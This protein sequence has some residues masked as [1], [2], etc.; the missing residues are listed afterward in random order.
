M[1]KIFI[2]N[3]FFGVGALVSFGIYWYSQYR[4]IPE[5]MVKSDFSEVLCSASE[6]RRIQCWQNQVEATLTTKGLDAAFE[7][8]AALFA[9]ETDFAQ[10]CHSFMH[11]LGQAAYK[12]FAKH[13]EISL[14]QKTSYCGFG[15]YHGFLEAMVFQTG[16]IHGAREFCAYAEQQLSAQNSDAKGACYHGIG[17]G[18]VDGSDSRSWGDEE[19]VISPGLK[20]CEEVT[21]S[22]YFINR[23]ASGVFNSLANLYFD[24]K[25]KLAIDPADPFRICRIQT[26]Q[27]FKKPCYEE[28]NTALMRLANNDFS[29][30]VG[31]LARIDESGYAGDAASSLA[32][33]EAHGYYRSSDDFSRVVTVCR[34]LRG[35]VVSSCLVGF[36]AGLV[37]HSP[38]G[39]EGKAAVRFCGSEKLQE[40]ERAACFSRV[41][42]YLGVVTTKEKLQK[43]CQTLDEK[44]KKYCPSEKAEEN[45]GKLNQDTAS[46]RGLKIL[47]FAGGRKSIASL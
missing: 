20:L 4:G 8:I 29:K 19:A 33:V 44:Y 9:T 14:T 12:K 1:K 2:K 25:Y 17:H 32:G 3:F 16:N 18:V 24:P 31:F 40:E 38:P 15:F 45:V 10:S 39:E 22:E 7:A 11:I 47:S 34:S 27:Y 43:I 35:E 21:D 28:M 37:E 6:G 41:I 42:W 46:V 23:C 26:K 36:A 30:A 13:E 5:N